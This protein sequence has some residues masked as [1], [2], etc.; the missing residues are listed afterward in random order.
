MRKKQNKTKRPKTTESKIESDFQRSFFFFLSTRRR[1]LTFFALSQKKKT[2]SAVCLP[3]ARRV[4]VL[5]ATEAPAGPATWI[6]SR[7][8]EARRLRR[9]SPAG[10]A[11]A[12]ALAR[13][14][15]GL[16]VATPFG[17]QDSSMLRVLAQSECLVI[18]EA[19]A[20]QAKAGDPCRIVRL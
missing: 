9:G 7:E 20:R 17:R 13:G 8:E 5:A 3:G 1:S 2:I 15:D 16:P 11:E 6:G 19:H 4:G 10:E 18:R 12:A 14:D